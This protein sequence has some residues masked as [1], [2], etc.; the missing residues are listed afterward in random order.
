MKSSHKHCIHKPICAASGDYPV[1]KGAIVM[2][3]I[4]AFLSP[5]KRQV[6]S[7]NPAIHFLTLNIGGSQLAVRN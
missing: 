2:Q 5:A 4:V 3:V 7:L 1:Q 6:S